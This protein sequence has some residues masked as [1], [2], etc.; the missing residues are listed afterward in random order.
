MPIGQ[1]VTDYETF[2][3]ALAE[4]GYQGALSYEMCSPLVGGGSMENLDRCA[5]ESLAY[6]RELVAKLDA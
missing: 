1:G 4:V 6:L 3:R 5:R 2:V